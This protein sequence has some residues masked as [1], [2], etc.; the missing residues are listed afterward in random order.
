MKITSYAVARPSYYDRNASSIMPSFAGVLSPTGAT[1]RYTYTVAA[2]K[3]ALIETSTAYIGRV[4]VA[5]TSGYF[6]SDTRITLASGAYV[7]LIRPNQIDNT[8]GP[9]YFASSTGTTTLYA[10]ETVSAETTDSSTGGTV[11]F[12]LASKGTLFDA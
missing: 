12:L 11:A 7:I 8:V 9:A 1:T 6:F 5:S 3:K 2:G 4:S 10:G